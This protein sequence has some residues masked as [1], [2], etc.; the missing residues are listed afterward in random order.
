MA[1]FSSAKER[2][3]EKGERRRGSGRGGVQPRQPIKHKPAIIPRC[4]LPTA[5]M[6]VYLIANFRAKQRERE[7]ERSGRRGSS[8]ATRQIKNNEKTL[9]KQQKK[10]HKI[11]N[12]NKLISAKRRQG[13]KKKQ[14]TMLHSGATKRGLN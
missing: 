13:T 9:K 3:V 10:Q 8:A 7:Q 14:K 4:R 5:L 6:P 12:I 1:T 11:S 2:I